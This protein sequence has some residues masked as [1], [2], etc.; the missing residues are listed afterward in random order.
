MCD[1]GVPSAAH[2]AGVAGID[3]YGWDEGNATWRWSG[4]SHPSFPVTT[5][6]LA[7]CTCRA[8]GC[9]PRKCVPSQL[10]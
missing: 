5:S 2:A 8:S 4:T 1:Y 3:M 9:L 10:Q 6:K 7:S